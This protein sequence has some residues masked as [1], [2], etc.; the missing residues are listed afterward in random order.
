MASAMRRTLVV[1][2]LTVLVAAG[3]AIPAGSLVLTSARGSCSVTTS[4]T[5]NSATVSNTNCHMVQARIVSL[6]PAGN[7][8]TDYGKWSL[9]I[10]AA[11]TTNSMVTGRYAQ[12]TY[13]GSLTQVQYF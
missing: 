1:G 4:K 5:V 11:R 13:G 12:A 2:A 9:T 7:P 10:S 6:T 8:V 3:S